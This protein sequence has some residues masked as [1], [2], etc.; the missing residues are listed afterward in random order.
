[1]KLNH[2]SLTEFKEIYFQEFGVTLSDEEANNLG[3]ALL[4]LFKILLRK[5]HL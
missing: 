2:V 5:P 1:M 3:I 4:R